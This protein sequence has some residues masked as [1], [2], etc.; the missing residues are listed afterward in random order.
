MPIL[1]WARYYRKQRTE[2]KLKELLKAK[3]FEDAV[4]SVVTGGLFYY[5][6]LNDREKDKFCRSMPNYTRAEIEQRFNVTLTLALRDLEVAELIIGNRK[7]AQQAQA[8]CEAVWEEYQ[9]LQKEAQS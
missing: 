8:E 4:I 5:S 1:G 9:R 2:K 3:G 7:D 6:E